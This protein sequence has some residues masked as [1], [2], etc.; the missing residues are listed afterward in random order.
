MQIVGFNL[1]ADQT[2]WSAALLCPSCTAVRN[3]AAPQP[4]DPLEPSLGASWCAPKALLLFIPVGACT[5]ISRQNPG[6]HTYFKPTGTKPAPRE[7]LFGWVF[8]FL[9]FHFKRA[10]ISTNEDCVD[11]DFSS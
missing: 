7:V 5:K 9:L 3:A 2:G 6:K 8:I 1:P 11:T 4:T 10:Q